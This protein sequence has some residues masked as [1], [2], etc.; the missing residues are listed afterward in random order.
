MG[1]IKTIIGLGGLWICG[2]LYLHRPYATDLPIGTTD[3]NSVAS[4]LNRL[5][6]EDRALVKAYVVRSGGHV[7]GA[8]REV[9]TDFTAKTF[10]EAIEIEKKLDADDAKNQKIAQAFQAEREKKLAPLK[11]IIDLKLLKREIVN[12]AYIGPIRYILPGETSASKVASIKDS[13]N[14]LLTTYQ[15]QNKSSKTISNLEITIEI[16]KAKRSANELGILAEC[17]IQNLGTP[18]AAYEV[19]EI[20]CS[21][22][23]HSASETDHQ[24]VTM[25]IQDLELKW[26]PRFIQ[27][28]DGKI[29]KTND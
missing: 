19:R 26:E 28:E 27:F 3:L 20:E 18:L 13:E 9:G 14:A 8:I 5:S 22:L 21:N 10:G 7:P 25:P 6:D 15:L 12:R 29:I 1:N 16:L 24:Y 23:G 17:F 2:W 11:E 4:E